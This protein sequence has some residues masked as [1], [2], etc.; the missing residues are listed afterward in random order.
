MSTRGAGDE[1]AV[2]T[3]LRGKH[4]G[5]ISISRPDIG[6]PCQQWLPRTRAMIGVPR[7]VRHTGKRT[8]EGTSIVANRCGV[9]ASP[10]CGA[11]TA[12]TGLRGDD[13]RRPT[14][15]GSRLMSA[16]DIDITG[17]PFALMP[18]H[19]RSQACAHAADR[20]PAPSHPWRAQGSAIRFGSASL[21]GCAAAG[22][23][24]SCRGRA[25]PPAPSDQF[26]QV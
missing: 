24:R 20:A 21:H 10:S 12:L 13:H 22:Q 9:S 6:G 15:C 14:L 8:G 19:G 7:P 26:D 11:V 16:R 5:P 23:R 3:R 17:S 4:D 18:S 25:R 1:G 2:S